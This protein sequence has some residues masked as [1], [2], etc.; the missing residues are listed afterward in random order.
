ME[1]RKVASTSIASVGY[2]D[3]LSRL[4]V[5]FSD[6]S[7][8]LYHLVPK[9]LHLELVQAVSMGQYFSERIRPTFRAER[10]R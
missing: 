8:Y 3:A 2:D 5:E 1:R 10:I 7:V 6:G 9:R 4:E